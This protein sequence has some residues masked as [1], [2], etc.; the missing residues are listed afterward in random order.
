MTYDE[1]VQKVVEAVKQEVGN[2]AWFQG[3]CLN[4]ID[5][6]YEIG[7]LG[8]AIT[9]ALYET[10]YHDAPNHGF[11]DN[12]YDLPDNEAD[13]QT[14]AMAGWGTDEDYGC[15]QDC[16]EAYFDHLERDHDEPYEGDM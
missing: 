13:A 5:E 15:Y 3:V 16:D 9:H 4:D 14:L 8:G 6:Y 11:E 2:E 10:L 12:E 1:F 7:D